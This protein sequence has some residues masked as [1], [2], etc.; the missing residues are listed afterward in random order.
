MPLSD[1]Q[2][3]DIRATNLALTEANLLRPVQFISTENTRIN[4]TAK[5]LGNNLTLM[6]VASELIP[7]SARINAAADGSAEFK[8]RFALASATDVPSH[9]RMSP[10]VVERIKPGGSDVGIT[11]TFP[12]GSVSIFMSMASG[13]SI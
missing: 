5:R 9:I 2:A 8:F 1:A 11:H 10:K 7:A 13:S 12:T 3:A 4:F 6:G